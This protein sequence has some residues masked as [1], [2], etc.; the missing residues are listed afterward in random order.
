MARYCEYCNTVIGD[1]AKFCN[2]CGKKQSAKPS[3]REEIPSW[4]GWQAP[5]TQNMRAQQAPPQSFAS[6]AATAPQAA[7]GAS[8]SAPTQ[9]ASTYSVPQ[10][11]PA[12]Q[13]TYGAQQTSPQGSAS[14]PGTYSAPQYWESYDFPSG[15]EPSANQQPRR[16]ASRP[17]PPLSSMFEDQQEAD[18]EELRE[19]AHESIMNFSLWSAGIVLFPIPFSDLILLM[20]IQSAMVINIGKIYNVKEPPERLLALLA[21]AC[22]ATVFGQIT[23]LFCA[24]LIPVI[25]K[26][27]AAPFVFGWTYGMG[28]VAV[29]YF[30]SKGQATD[31]ELKSLFKKASKEAS[32]SYDKTKQIKPSEALNNIREYVSEEEYNKIRERFG[33][34]A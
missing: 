29:R 17:L 21:G 27:I 6:P 12:G 28:E 20:P 26:L 15:E 5:P 2:R 16:D 4:S 33:P 7:Q 14:Q 13:Y 10:P 31:D 19:R 1:N 22:G 24:N 32:K 9:A 23:M 30:E 34:Q 18:L 8:Y 25:G 3:A 11:P